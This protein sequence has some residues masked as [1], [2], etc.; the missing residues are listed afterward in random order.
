MNIF[1]Y[2]YVY[3]SIYMYTHISEYIHT[4]IH[5]IWILH[6]YSNSPLKIA[7]NALEEFN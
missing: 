5:T 4:Y 3:I 1:I 7:S 6:V 2:I